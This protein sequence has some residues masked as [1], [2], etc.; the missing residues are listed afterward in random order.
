M[1]ARSLPQACYLRVT[2]AWGP[3]RAKEAAEAEVAARQAAQEEAERLRREEEAQQREAA[4]L[5]TL[6][7]EQEARAKVPALPHLLVA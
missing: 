1:P 3:D 7:L 5:E 4:R 2:D 6:R